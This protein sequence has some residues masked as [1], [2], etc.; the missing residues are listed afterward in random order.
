[1]EKIAVLGAGNGGHACSADLS[2]A[3]Y[4]VDLF[5]LPKF[6]ASIEPI[7][8]RGGIEIVGA[9][10][11][12]FAKIRKVTTDI[13]DAIE[14]V[15]LIL[16]VVPAFAQKTFAEVCIPY[17]EDGQTVVF[18][19]KGGGALEFVKILKDRGIKKDITLGETSTLPYTARIIGPAQVKA[20]AAV[21]KLPIAA[22]PA[23]YTEKLINIMKEIYPVVPASNV[24]ETF[25]LDLNAI[26]HPAPV[27]LNAA[28]IESKDEFFLYAEGATPSVAKVVEAVDKERLAVMEALDLK[29]IPFTELVYALGLVGGKCTTIFEAF[30]SPQGI[31]GARDIKAPSTLYARYITEDIPYGLV[32]LASLAEMVEVSTPVINSLITIAS[33]LNQV[34]YRKE[35]RTVE[36]L[37]ISGLNT[38]ELRRYLTSGKV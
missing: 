16:I 20:F 30:T 28:R 27:I 10:R 34:D 17:I 15:D 8:E 21:K 9:A 14:G 38:E 1:M 25:L 37:G 5:E 11:V 24:L 22:F 13:K 18:M 26:V 2:L 12:G 7:I 36:K 31:I 4:E 6:K 23:R 29:P 35:G 19:G 33:V 3:G 32:L